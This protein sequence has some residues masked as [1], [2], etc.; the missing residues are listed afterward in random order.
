MAFLSVQYIPTYTK[1]GEAFR[2]SS[3]GQK[4]VN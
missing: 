1:A 4:A 2:E 3:Q